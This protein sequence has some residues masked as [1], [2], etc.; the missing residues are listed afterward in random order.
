M[1]ALDRKLIRDLMSLKGQIVAIALVMACGI[2][3]FVM[4]LSALV[5]LERTLSSYYEQQRFAMVFASL[6]RAP[7]TLRERIADIPG[8]AQLQTRIVRP[9]TLDV[10]GFA[11]PVTGRLISVDGE[12]PVGLNTLYLRRGRW[13]DPRRRGEALVTESFADAHGLQPGDSVRAIINGKLERLELVGMVLSPEFVYSI[14]EGELLPDEK[15]FAVLW[16]H[17]EQLEAAFNMDGA[18]NDVAL[19]LEPVRDGTGASAALEAEVIARLDGLL[20]PYGS[21]GAYGR[22]DHASHEFVANEIRELRSMALVAPTI[23]MSVAAFLL[24]VVVSRLV[25]TQR[26][27]IAMLKAV[28]YSRRAI[29]WHYLKLVL[30]IAQI[31]AVFGVV[32]GA[33]LGRNLTIIYSRFFQFPDFAFALDLRAVA[34][35]V[36]VSAAAALAGTVAAV[37]RATRLPA[38]EAMRPA[39][40]TMYRPMLLERLGLGRVLSPAASMVLRHL[41]RRPVRSG[42]SVLGIALAVAM[43]VIGSYMSDAIDYVIDHQFHLRQRQQLT[44]GFAEPTQGDVLYD[45][46]H[47]PGVQRVEPFRTLPARLRAGH[48]Q[49]RIGV[50]ALPEDPTLFRLLSDRGVEV[51]LPEHGLLLSEKLAELLRVRPGDWITLEVLEAERPVARVLVAETVREFTGVSAYMHIDAANRLMQRD[52]MV[53]G[54]FVAADEA[55]IPQLYDEL[56]RIPHV[57][58]VSV[59]AAMVESFERTVAENIMIMRTFNILFACVIAVGIVY[60]SAR[61]AVSERG[62]ELATLRVVGFTRAEVSFI[63]LGELGVLVA[64]AIPV[65][66]LLGYAMAAWTTSAFD[67]ELFRLPLIIRRSTYAF[68][69]LVTLAAAM[70]SGLAV[71]RRLNRLDLVA[72]LKTRE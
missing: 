9:V 38:A 50:M 5:S 30:V 65:G 1:R 54:A 69:A 23:F 10:P 70:G 8:V 60:N 68:A 67:T 19:T 36:G 41:E 24:N 48:L 40:P 35:S 12:R 62:R 25:S 49:R 72:V 58:T 4:S 39:A 7:N 15:R 45:V 11:E 47:L 13:L 18:F 29:G 17:V 31:G 20:E 34:G 64:A 37:W 55:A 14:R 28:G 46:A 52:R 6:K 3:T 71:R 57:A 61:I 53:S 56:K 22:E 2:A 16:M 43:L 27:Q 42:L 26:E 63:L 51:A 21:I 66:L 33:W 32:L 59:K 44:I